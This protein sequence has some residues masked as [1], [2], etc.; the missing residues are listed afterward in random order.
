M[1]H[2]RTNCVVI[3]NSLIT[4]VWLSQQ[5]DYN[6]NYLNVRTNLF[7]DIPNCWGAKVLWLEAFKIYLLTCSGDFVLKQLFNC[8]STR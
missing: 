5:Q 4:Y 1:H 2:N 7:H 8:I 3:P 6:Y